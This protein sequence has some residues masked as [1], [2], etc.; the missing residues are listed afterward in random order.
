MTAWTCGNNPSAGIVHDLS[1]NVGALIGRHPDLVTFRDLA[2]ICDLSA[3]ATCDVLLRRGVISPDEAKPKM[4]PILGALRGTYGETPLKRISLALSTV[5]DGS[6][7]NLRRY[8]GARRGSGCLPAKA[9]T[10][11][12]SGT[13]SPAVESQLPGGYQRRQRTPGG[14]LR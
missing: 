1:G 10:T 2:G 3:G 12:V 8:S 9:H 5:D 11:H 13:A 6:R 4:L 7:T 14:A